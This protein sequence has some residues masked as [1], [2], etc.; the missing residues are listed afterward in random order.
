MLPPFAEFNAGVVTEFPERNLVIPGGK[1][2]APSV[3]GTP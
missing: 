2:G 1:A 3:E